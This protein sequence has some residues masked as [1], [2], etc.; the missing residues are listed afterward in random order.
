MI[1]VTSLVGP[2][3]RF[4]V[5]SPWLSARTEPSPENKKRDLPCS[6]VAETMPFVL[7]SIH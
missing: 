6:R 1:N 5:L 4:T 2:W 7:G 3:T